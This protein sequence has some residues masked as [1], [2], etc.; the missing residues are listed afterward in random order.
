ML[1]SV[2]TSEIRDEV[3][4]QPFGELRY[5]LK[6]NGTS[7]PTDLLYTGQRRVA[8]V[9]LYYY[10]ARWVDVQTGHFTQPDTVTKDG[11]DHFG[12]VRNNPIQNIDPTG[13]TCWI[14]SNG[15]NSSCLVYENSSF[16]TAVTSSSGAMGIDFIGDWSTRNKF[17]VLMA[18]NDVG[19]KFSDSLSYLKGSSQRAFK[20]VYKKGVTFTWGTS[21]A[22]DYCSGSSGFNGGGCTNNSR[23]IN[24][25]T[26]VESNLT[27]GGTITPG[28]AW[29]SAVNNIVHELGHAFASL[30]YGSGGYLPG[31]PNVNIPDSLR[32][33]QT[34]FMPMDPPNQLTW[35]QHP[36]T[37]EGYEIFADMFLG[38]TYGVWDPNPNTIG[39]D[40][41]NFMNQ[42]MPLWIWEASIDY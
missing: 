14:Y 35:R 8:E 33:N 36:K 20:E 12:Y 28:A 30:W 10:N 21:G 2:T 37:T 13:H 27:G 34:G 17:A 22:Q 1:D 42:Y 6:S 26:L 38:W 25:V 9:G 7:L 32:I 39:S 24:F 15:Y 18:A 19:N 40:R 41:D 5:Q 31:G 16:D 29:T 3:R 23:S 11:F 4:Y